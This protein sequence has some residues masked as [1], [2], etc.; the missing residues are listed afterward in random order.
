MAESVVKGTGL[1]SLAALDITYPSRE[2]FVEMQ[3]ILTVIAAPVYGG[4]VA[5]TAVQRLRRIRAWNCPCAV[6]AV[7]GNRDYDD[8][9]L[10]LSNEAASCGFT[11]V[12]AAAFI[13][14]HSYST[15]EYPVAAGR[16][17]CID[18]E[19]ARVFGER[20]T[21]IIRQLDSL[22]KISIP[23]VKG[24]Q[25][26]RAYNAT[27]AT[28]STD[29]NL[30]TQCGICIAICSTGSIGLDSQIVSD[31]TSCI[32]C[33]TCVKQCPE[34]ARIFHTPYSALLNKNCNGRKEPECIFSV[35]L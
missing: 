31:V 24:N 27:L 29:V 4:R 22:E 28:P 2:G 21:Q 10:E 1:P 17:D 18:M 32:K 8:A 33:C 6:V 3:N 13:G 7:Y 23:P 30:C 34:Q 14:E 26:Y 15:A 5:S 19:K 9:L 11:P 25:P 20:I 16:P 12:A 35:I